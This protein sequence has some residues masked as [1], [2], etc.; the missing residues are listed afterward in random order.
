[1]VENMDWK[2]FCAECGCS[3]SDIFIDV[4]IGELVCTQCG[5]VLPDFIWLKDEIYE[6]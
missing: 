2:I 5:L 6:K 4:Y 1:M 3:G